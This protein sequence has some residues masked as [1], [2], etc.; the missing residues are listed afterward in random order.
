[1][2]ADNYFSKL[3]SIFQYPSVLKDCAR[4]FSTIHGVQ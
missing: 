4:L 1:M 2:L 3:T